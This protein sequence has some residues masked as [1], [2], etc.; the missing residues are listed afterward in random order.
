MSSTSLKLLQVL[1]NKSQRCFPIQQPKPLPIKR[2]AEETIDN[3]MALI[4]QSTNDLKKSRPQK[5]PQEK[6]QLLQPVTDREVDSF[7]TRSDQ[8]KNFRIPK[9]QESSATLRNDDKN[10]NVRQDDTVP[11]S[12]EAVL[13]R[14]ANLPPERIAETKINLKER[15]QA[16]SER[17]EERITKAADERHGPGISKAAIRLADH[18]C[19]AAAEEKK[20]GTRATPPPAEVQMFVSRSDDPLLLERTYIKQR[21]SDLEKELEGAYK[22][23]RE[24]LR[25]PKQRSPSKHGERDM[26]QR[27]SHEKKHR[28]HRKESRS[29]RRASHG[30]SQSH[31]HCD[32]KEKSESSRKEQIN[33]KDL[34]EIK[35]T[36][37]R[38]KKCEPINPWID[39]CGL[40]VMSTEAKNEDHPVTSDLL[41]GTPCHYHIQSRCL[42]VQVWEFLPPDTPNV[43]HPW[44]YSPIAALIVPT[45]LH[46]FILEWMATGEILKS[47]KYGAY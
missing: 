6:E 23:R 17:R 10:S 19:R 28:H 21:I 30:R 13:Q 8:R 25:R 47:M 42:P 24:L 27:R 46:V 16:A 45:L 4:E 15:L 7:T 34:P 41:L 1:S 5:P 39:V 2:E 38:V 40:Q 20:L 9:K 18:F 36:D 32:G 31:K 43:R 29:D 22:E 33:E 12:N 11:E 35:P 44:R 26:S 37:P 14:L 3:I